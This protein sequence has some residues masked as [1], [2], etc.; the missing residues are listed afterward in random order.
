M[1]NHQVKNGVI[2]YWQVITVIGL[3]LM[4]FASLRSEVT[5]LQVAFADE[6]QDV[7]SETIKRVEIE[8]TLVKVETNQETF[9]EDIGEIKEE[10]KEQGKKLDKILERLTGD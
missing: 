4:G 3:G 6:R 5:A 8:K 1:T 9:R 2:R 10:L 7:R